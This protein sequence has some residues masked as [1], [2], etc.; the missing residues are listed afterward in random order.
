MGTKNNVPSNF[1]ST[2]QY[3]YKDVNDYLNQFEGIWEFINGTEKF[4]IVLTKIIKYHSVSPSIN[5]DI[6]RDGISFK[7]KKFIN[8]S[9]VFESPLFNY[10]SFNTVD[11]K[12]LEGNIYDYGRL[13]RTLYFPQAMGGGV[14]IEG[15]HPFI[16]N[17]TIELLPTTNHPSSGLVN[18]KIKFSLRLRGNNGEYN[19]PAYDGMPVFSIPNDVIMT[20]VP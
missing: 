8:N 16:A 5:V 7:Y 1:D 11:G 17:C 6:F 3:Y 2:G 14:A 9:L 10:P 4:Q 18:P 12:L 15:G 20:K 19:N 13:S